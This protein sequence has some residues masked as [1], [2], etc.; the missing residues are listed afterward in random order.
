MSTFNQPSVVHERG[1][2]GGELILAEFEST[3]EEQTTETHL[4]LP[5]GEGTVAILVEGDLRGFDISVSQPEGGVWDIVAPDSQR[6]QQRLLVTHS[7]QREPWRLRFTVWAK[8]KLKVTITYLSQV[9]KRG[10]SRLTCKACKKL[11][12]VLIAALITGFHLPDLFPDKG[13][14][15]PA[16]WKYLADHIEKAWHTLPDAV[17]EIFSSIDSNFVQKFLSAF[18]WAIDAIGVVSTF[19]DTILTAICQKLGFCPAAP[20]STPA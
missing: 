14:L 6:D 5:A 13:D 15:P 2:R 4:D 9:M 12:R 16:L 19:I 20:K 10:W 7:S 18:K 17:Q 1:E 8:G 11:M 3:G